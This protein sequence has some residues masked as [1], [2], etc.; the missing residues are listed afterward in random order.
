MKEFLE[1]IL[2]PISKGAIG[3]LVISHGDI[4]KVTALMYLAA[5][6]LEGLN[7]IADAL[8]GA[9]MRLPVPHRY[10]PTRPPC[11]AGAGDS[12]V[13]VSDAVLENIVKI[14]AAYRHVEA[15]VSV[16]DLQVDAE[17]AIDLIIKRHSAG[18]ITAAYVRDWLLGTT[19]SAQYTA[20][21][22]L[23]AGE[24]YEYRGAYYLCVSPSDK[25][26]MR[27]TGGRR[28]EVI[29]SPSN[30]DAKA[31][32]QSRNNIEIVAPNGA[33]VIKLNNKE[34]DV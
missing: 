2:T 18:G 10:N 30:E 6:I 13:E 7:S 33:L 8:R 3:K 21:P 11:P 34:N 14:I 4:V 5:C 32:R 27:L 31:I 28:E 24:L 26:F 16:Q 23:Q 17:E 22:P 12:Y 29:I 9:Q 1:S 15:V 25:R 20:R 19:E